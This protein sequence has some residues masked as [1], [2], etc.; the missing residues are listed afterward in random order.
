MFFHPCFLPVSFLVA[1]LVGGVD[2]C[3]PSP[4]FPFPCLLAWL[5]NCTSDDG[6][7]QPAW[8]K[9][10]QVQPSTNK[11]KQVQTSTNKYSQVA[12]LLFFTF[13]EYNISEIERIALRSCLDRS[14][15]SLP[16]L[17]TTSIKLAY[18][19]VKMVMMMMMVQKARL[20]GNCKI[21]IGPLPLA[22]D[23]SYG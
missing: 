19:I 18:L 23:A 14:I 3:L 15:L 10:N 12:F 5:D 17:T 1:F 13:Q 8:T 6:T 16:G 4:L 7:L 2:I 21:L 11:Y 9:Y 22:A 20:G